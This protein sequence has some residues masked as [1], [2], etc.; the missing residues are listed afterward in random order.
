MCRGWAVASLDKG[1]FRKTHMMPLV[2]ITCA[3]LEG[4]FRYT[5]SSYRA[6]ALSS[7]AGI[8]MNKYE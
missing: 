5:V 8:S 7:Q 6:Q 2:S 3:A 1:N 4:E